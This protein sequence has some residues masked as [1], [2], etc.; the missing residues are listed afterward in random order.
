MQSM[1]WTIA[2]LGSRFNLLF[3][4]HKKQVMHSALG[5]F[6]DQPLDLAVGFVEP[7]GTERTL[8]LTTRG[9]PLIA[10]EQFERFNS[11][12]FRGHSPEHR[13]RFELN[14]HSVFY[15]QDDRLCVLP[16]FFLE[17]RVSPTRMLRWVEAEGKTPKSVRLFIR[18]RRPDTEIAASDAEGGRIELSYRNGLTPRLDH[19]HETKGHREALPD[20]PVRER[21]QSLN[22]DA[23]P[24]PEGDGLTLEL[25]VTEEG[26]GV[27][28]RLVWGAFVGDPVMRVKRDGE[29][30]DARFRYTR[31]WDSLDAVMNEAIERRDE[32]LALSRRLEK[33]IDQA[34]INPAQSHLLHQGFQA[35]LSNTWWCDLPATNGAGA[36]AEAGPRPRSGSAC[37]R[38][39]AFST[40]RWTWSS[41]SRCFIYP[42][43]RSC[44]GCSSV[45]GPTRPSRTKNRRGRISPTTWAGGRPPMGRRIRTPCR[46]RRT[47]TSCC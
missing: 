36:G 2:R 6:L 22:E 47:R 38:G 25:P 27:K 30:R 28:W 42:C 1:T 18:L 21:I 26:S 16:A 32:L 20:V 17:M 5:R 31:Y 15:P 19:Q 45:S 14:V 12:T 33:L 10:S 13:L 39:L 43:G 40:R 29:L 3:E 8:P 23:E 24:T 4:P 41:T 44:C 34:P 46:W 7:D 9:E 37:G 11:I 35:Y